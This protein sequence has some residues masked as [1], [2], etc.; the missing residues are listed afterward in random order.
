MRKR[1]G[2]DS[3]WYWNLGRYKNR[4]AARMAAAFIAGRGFVAGF[5]K[6]SGGVRQRCERRLLYI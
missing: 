1:L 4:A 2:L 6:T 5:V 3:S